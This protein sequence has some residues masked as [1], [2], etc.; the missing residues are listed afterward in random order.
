MLS[1]AVIPQKRDR[2][3]SRGGGGKGGQRKE[4]RDVAEDDHQQREEDLKL[5][6][7]YNINLNLPKSDDP[8]FGELG[9]IVCSNW[10]IFS[11]TFN[12]ERAFSK[13]MNSLN[14]L[15]GP[16]AHCRPLAKDE[17]VRLR[18][19]VRDWFR[20]MEGGGPYGCFDLR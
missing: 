18:L 10:T 14:I 2:Q 15:R 1:L 17:A 13:V 9:E 12:A 7:S 6:L 5:N 4:R 8:T 11:D 3:N 20:L 19:T 16:I